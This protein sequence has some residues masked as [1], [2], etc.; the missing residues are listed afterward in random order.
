MSAT[1]VRNSLIQ[2][3]VCWERS[4]EPIRFTGIGHTNFVGDKGLD[5]GGDEW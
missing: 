4:C 5:I 1:I 2:S 3:F